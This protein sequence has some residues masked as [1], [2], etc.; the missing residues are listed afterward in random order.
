MVMI[1]PIIGKFNYIVNKRFTSKGNKFTHLKI[2]PCIA[3]TIVRTTKRIIDD[4]TGIQNHHQD[5]IIKIKIDDRIVIRIKIEVIVMIVETAV[6]AGDAIMNTMIEKIVVAQRQNIV[7]I[8]NRTAIICHPL[9]IR[10]HRTPVVPMYMRPQHIITIAI[11]IRHRLII[12][13]V[14][15]HFISIH[16]YRMCPILRSNIQFS[17]SIDFSYSDSLGF[18]FE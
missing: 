4:G 6:A 16:R 1:A 2:N 17:Y 12:A 15:H 9:I 18:A 5:T 11:I 3:G 13:V 14:V 8:K 10:I 7:T